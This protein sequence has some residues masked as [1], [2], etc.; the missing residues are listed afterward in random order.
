MSLMHF[1]LPFRRRW[2]FTQPDF[3]RSS[4]RRRPAVRSREPG[5]LPELHFRLSR[6]VFDT[7][8]LRRRDPSRHAESIR[9]R[10]AGVDPIC[11]VVYECVEGSRT[12]FQLRP[13]TTACVLFDHQDEIPIPAYL[14]CWAS[15]I[16]G[17]L[18]SL[19]FRR[20]R[21]CQQM[22][23]LRV[24]I[25]PPRGRTPYGRFCGLCRCIV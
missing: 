18:C 20:V 25:R 11:D 12:T 4:R 9:P 5:H 10:H 8:Y 15:H 6:D 13:S 19:R 16:G 24:V 3:C 23:L 2:A 17:L 14:S 22:H 21:Q 1:P 7:C